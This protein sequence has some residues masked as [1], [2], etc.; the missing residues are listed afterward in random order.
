M[1]GPPNVF[2]LSADSL[3]ASA[4][5]DT[6]DRLAG[7]VGG[8]RFRNAVA[9]AAHT[10]SSVPA[11]ATG[12]FVDGTGPGPPE[13]A[14]GE[15]GAPGSLL[16]R[17]REAGYETVLVTDNPLVSASLGEGGGLSETGLAR[18][19][20]ALPRS[21]TRAVERGYFGAIWPLARRLGLLGP[22]YRP[23]TALQDRAHERVA[24]ADGPV[25][26][27]IHYMDAHSPYWPP[28]VDGRDPDPGAYRTSALSRSL[29]VRGADAVDPGDLRDVRDLYGRTCDALGTAVERFVARLREAGQ[30]DPAADVLAVT[31]DHGEC[32]DP[33]R[34][35]I[36]HVPPASWES[37]VHVPLLVARP[38]WPGT[39]V[40]GQVSLV[41]LPR[42]LDVG[43]GSTPDPPAFAR[44]HAFTV[45]RTLGES[46]LVRGVRSA[47]G[48]K[49]FGRRT[50]EGV[51]V[52]RTA[53]EVGDP[54][55]EEVV[56]TYSPDG[57]GRGP[58]EADPLVAA[59]ARRGGPVGDADDHR[60]YDESQLRALGYLE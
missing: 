3:Q 16:A 28:P 49:L 46:S 39:A 60:R 26:C 27:W 6:V 11:L 44:E 13:R 2:L 52:V 48:E 10:A 14:G 41:D 17:F 35:V 45:A 37:L 20:E 23:A 1:D 53:F 34:G 50:G 22:Y 54:G 9:P 40:D 30:Y 59:L 58:G 51:D 36:G 19:D 42:L 57:D 29:A 12:R 8:T 18:L 21:L 5:A 56:E 55:T 24:A 43:G 33:E 38:D 25:F 4:F 7:R 15:V 47:D 31:A 32:L